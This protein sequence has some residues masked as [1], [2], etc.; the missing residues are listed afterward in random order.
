METR[1]CKRACKRVLGVGASGLGLVRIC[2]AIRVEFVPGAPRPL[3]EVKNK[4]TFRRLAGHS[5]EITRNERRGV[6]LAPI[7][8]TFAHYL[9]AWAQLRRGLNL[10]Y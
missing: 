6:H 3:Y 10:A 2:F 4:S 7:S 8:S 5:R 1:A 9:R